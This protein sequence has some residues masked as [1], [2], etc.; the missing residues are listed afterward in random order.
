MKLFRRIEHRVQPTLHRALPGVPHFV[1]QGK[2]D[3]CNRKPKPTRLNNQP[4]QYCVSEER[5]SW[6]WIVVFEE[7]GAELSL[8]KQLSA[9][10]CRGAL[11]D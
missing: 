10:P 7:I 9:P 3:F 8:L 1:P 5:N 4:T 2:K 11:A 6:G